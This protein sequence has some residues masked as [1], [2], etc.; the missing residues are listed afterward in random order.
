MAQFGPIGY[1]QF[2]EDFWKVFPSLKRKYG[3][4]GLFSSGCGWASIRSS[5]LLPLTE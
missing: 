1:K 2:V 5:K 4:D 3:K